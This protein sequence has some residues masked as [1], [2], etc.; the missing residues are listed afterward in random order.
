MSDQWLADARRLLDAGDAGGAFRALRPVLAYPA[1][2]LQG[3]DELAR[4]LDVFAAVA[5]AI[6]GDELGLK[7]AAAAAAPDDVDALYDAAYA[8]YEESLHDV[9]ASLLDRANRVA[10]GRVDLVSELVANLEA[11]L[12][13]ADAARVVAGSGLDGNDPLATYLAGF[14][15][16][17]LGDVEVARQRVAALDCAEGDVAFMRD[18]LRGMVLRAD[19]LTAAGVTLDR[20]ALTAWQAVIDGTVLLHE[21]PYG[22]DDGMSGR[23]AYV[24]DSPGLMR[25]GVERLR[26]WLAAT[27]RR[28][29]RVVAAPDRS[30]RILALAVARALGVPLEAWSPGDVAPGL[31]VAWDLDAVGDVDFLKALHRHAPGQLLFAHASAWVEPFT[32][33]PDVTT[34][35]YQTIAN[36]YAG[37]A[38]RGDAATGELTR[39]EADARDEE[40]LAGEILG[41]ERD[42]ASAT[43]LDVA[44][45]VTRAL[46]GLPAAHAMGAG[47]V[48]GHRR[49]QRAGSPVPSSFFL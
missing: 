12:R 48:A 30:S 21:S 36:P 41:D 43:P 38:L 25:E 16:M 17:M 35:L 37:G 31:V 24:S 42:E 13:Y 6:A 18:E 49:R 22:Y 34:I 14:C 11:R 26:A 32:Y 10:P 7:V 15:A 23:Y 19:A 28:P 47:R 29:P 45:A 9:A 5:E 3:A 4:A 2:E 46:E 20:R 8:L 33:A 44:I 1:P 39:S 27:G 40:A